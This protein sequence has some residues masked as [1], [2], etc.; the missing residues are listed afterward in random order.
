MGEAA[1]VFKERDALYQLE[2]SGMQASEVQLDSRFNL[3]D[4]KKCGAQA[5]KFE[6]I[7]EEKKAVKKYDGKAAKLVNVKTLYN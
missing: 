4:D 2:V 3:G 7:K 5:I 1:G 6:E